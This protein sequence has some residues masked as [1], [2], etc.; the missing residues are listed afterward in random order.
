MWHRFR[1]IDMTPFHMT[2]NNLTYVPWS[3]AYA[4]AMDEFGDHW[5]YA[6]TV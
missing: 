4:I 2:K 5:R 6:G 1:A 3:R